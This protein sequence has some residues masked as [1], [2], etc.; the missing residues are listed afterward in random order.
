MLGYLELCCHW[1]CWAQLDLQK[2]PS[3]SNSAGG[4]EGPEEKE[5][6]TSCVVKEVEAVNSR[7]SRNQSAPSSSRCFGRCERE[8]VLG[9][10]LPHMSKFT[11]RGTT[12]RL[13]KFADQAR[14]RSLCVEAR[15]W[16]RETSWSPIWCLRGK[17]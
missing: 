17:T 5:K 15:V 7:L 12:P 2:L 16:L 8:R 3:S 14:S 11:A 4:G 1:A 6:D 10:Y 9:R 13:R